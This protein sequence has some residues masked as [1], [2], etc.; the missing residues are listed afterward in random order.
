MLVNCSQLITMLP[1]S[2]IHSL[3]TNIAVVTG[4]TILFFFLARE[5]SLLYHNAIN[6]YV[7]GGNAWCFYR[8]L[9]NYTMCA[10][11]LTFFATA[12]CIREMPKTK[13]RIC[14]FMNC[15]CGCSNNSK[16]KLK[17]NSNKSWIVHS[18]NDPSSSKNNSISF[19]DLN[20]TNCNWQK[21]HKIFFF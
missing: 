9:I 2:F 13:I 6:I 19:L 14:N 16:I 5:L 21:K 18:G 20:Q 10:Y 1:F 4:L 7:R 11:I 15:P 8:F 17:R 12:A 3:L